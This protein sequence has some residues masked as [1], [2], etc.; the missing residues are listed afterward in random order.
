LRPLSSVR[1]KPA[2]PIAGT[3]LI[4]RILRYARSHG[5]RQAVINLHHLP[6]TITSVVGDGSDVDIAVKYSWEWPQVLGSAGGPRK[7]L[8]LLGD[9][10]FFIVNGDTICDVDLEALAVQHIETGALV[11]MAVIE[12]RWPDTYGGVV[13][14]AQGRV[15]GFVPRGSPAAKYHF[16][17]VQLVHPSV[18]ADLP[19]DQ[20]AETVGGVYPRLIASRPGS[21]RAFLA[22]AEFWDVGTPSNYLETTLEIG[23]REG[24]AVPQIGRGTAIDRSARIADSV[25]WDRAEVGP[26]VTLERCVVADGVRIPAGRRFANCAIIQ[27]EGDL[28]VSPMSHG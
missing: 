17:G 26:G 18:F 8:P 2:V 14:D 11:T 23:R 12:N 15:Y 7:A 6:D 1:A 4:T 27:G 24:A 22:D 25:I 5:V 21:V 10:E 13:T 9:E 3:P 19:L 28:V 16:V 20:P